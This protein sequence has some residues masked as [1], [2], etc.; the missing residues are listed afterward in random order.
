MTATFADLS[1]AD[2]LR[3][4]SPRAR[5]TLWSKLGETPGA[6]TDLRYD[7][8]RFWARPEQV[9]ETA[10][11][12]GH[13]LIVISGGRREGKTRAAVELFVREVDEGRAVRPRVFAASVAD[14]DKSV[15]HGVSGI[16]TN[17]DPEQRRRWTW[18]QDQGPA[19][20]VRVR[21]KLGV[22]VEIVCFTAQSPEGAV[23]YAGDLDLY[24]DVAKWG[25]AALTTWTHARISCSEGYACGIVATT[26]RGTA[27]IRKLLAGNTDG[28]LVRNLRLG[29]NR[30][31]LNARWR[32]Q[33]RAELADV[34]GDTL[35]QEL[36]DEDIAAGTPFEGLPWEKIHVQTVRRE[37]LEDQV[38]AVDPADGA[39]GGHD[40]WGLGAAGRR[41]DRRVVVLED[42]SG[43]YDDARAGERIL[44]L[45]ERRGIHKIIVEVNRGPR[46]LSALRA[47]HL[48][49]E[50]E[51]LRR[52]PTAPPRAMPEVIPIVAQEGKRLRAGPVRTL[53]L[54]GLV[55]HLPGLDVLDRRGGEPRSLEKQMREWDPDAPKRPRQ[56]DRV[57]WLVHAV[58]YLAS[59]GGKPGEMS[60]HEQQIEAAT[61]AQLA[62]HM[63]SMI[64][65]SRGVRQAAPPPGPMKVPGVPIGDARYAGPPPMGGGFVSWQRR[66]AF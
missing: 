50:L 24:D 8:D 61:Q 26:R 64:A 35:R 25:P 11:I 13:G 22:T 36:D 39:G 58:T 34:A 4:L 20:I 10:D 14:V 3:L 7:W 56:D 65:A 23:S 30:W 46:V 48:S 38:V 29:G 49:R 17:L 12:E 33:M 47:A 52:D 6:I 54:D 43:S 62:A 45:C 31:N 28:V 19:G 16:L 42:Q 44:D 5:R 63:S 1:L 27:L 53:Y 57:D 55:Q 9:F 18:I 66:K 15:M 40:E 59:L 2:R 60:E 32:S 41:T 21:N 37:E 51:R